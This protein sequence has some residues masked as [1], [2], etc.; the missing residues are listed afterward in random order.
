MEQ[1]G[2]DTIEVDQTAESISIT[3]ASVL[4]HILSGYGISSVQPFVETLQL[5]PFRYRGPL[6]RYLSEYCRVGGAYPCATGTGGINLARPNAALAGYDRLDTRTATVLA[7]R[8]T[9]EVD[10]VRN[11]GSV[12]FPRAGSVVGDQ[13]EQ[14]VILGLTTDAMTVTPPDAAARVIT[15]S[16]TFPALASGWSYTAS[17]STVSL[18]NVVANV[19][20]QFSTLGQPL[21]GGT[22]QSDGVI[23]PVVS[24]SLAKQP[25]ETWTVQVQVTFP[26]TSWPG[27]WLWQQIDA[28]GDT[29]NQ[30]GSVW[31]TS[32]DYTAGELINL[33][34]IWG[35]AAFVRVK[36]NVTTPANI[37]QDVA[38]GDGRAHTSERGL[39]HLDT[40]HTDTGPGFTGHLDHTD[41]SHSDA[42]PEHVDATE[43]TYSDHTDGSHSDRVH[44]DRVHTDRD[45]I[46]AAHGDVAH[47]DD[48]S[49]GNDIPHTDTPHEDI[50]HVDIPHSNISHLDTAQA[51]PHSD[52]TYPARSVEI[53]S[54]ASIERWGRRELTY[55]EWFNRSALGGL[56]ARMSA[57]GEPRYSWQ[58]DFALIQPNTALTQIV[59]G[60]EPGEYIRLTNQG[61]SIGPG[62]DAVCLVVHAELRFGRGTPIKRLTLLDTGSETPLADPVFLDSTANPVFLDSVAN[63]VRLG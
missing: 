22:S 55:P 15:R 46:D 19:V 4:Q 37:Y 8:P 43:P 54:P 12:H 36:L 16:L 61:S 34:R 59:T 30:S 31:G 50:S 2:R 52:Q 57:L 28:D 11:A 24:F 23:D 42:P 3:S 7:I 56:Q 33:D 48:I 6:A 26:A 32:A 44:V 27:T 35:L 13:V 38:H 45:N 47:F 17:A 49:F 53:L 5:G 58:A 20:I 29:H 9:L 14:T 25:D 51:S 40:P 21:I 10:H 62:I 60:L 41:G 1:A 18:L 63:P 39:S